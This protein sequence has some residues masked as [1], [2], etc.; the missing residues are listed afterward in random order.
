[1]NHR[2]VS[3][4]FWTFDGCYLEDTEELCDEYYSYVSTINSKNFEEKTNSTLKK[5][6][7]VT[8][9]FNEAIFYDSRAFH[10]PVIDKYYTRENPRIMMRLSY[11]LND[12]LD[13]D[14][15]ECYDD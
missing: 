13:D 11:V 15:G 12:G 1:M 2:D 8:Y 3:T 10:S 4:R 14:C 7:D 9:G 5:A 6:F